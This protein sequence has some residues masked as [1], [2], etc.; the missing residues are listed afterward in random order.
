MPTTAMAKTAPDVEEPSGEITEKPVDQK[1]WWS[2]PSTITNDFERL[3]NMLNA[4]RRTTTFSPRFV[5]PHLGRRRAAC[6]MRFR[7]W[8]P[9][10]NLCRIICS[11][12]FV[13]RVHEIREFAE[14]LIQNLDG[15][16][17]FPALLEGAPATLEDMIQVFGKPVS[18]DDAQAALS[19]IQRLEPPG[20]GSPRLAMLCCKSAPTRRCASLVTLITS[21]LE[22]LAE[23]RLP[24]IERKTGY[25]LEVI[26]AA[27]EELLHLNPRP[28]RDFE[29]ASAPNVV[30]DIS[31]EQDANGKY[32]VRLEDEYTPRLNISRQYQQCCQRRGRP[33]N[34]GTSIAIDSSP[35]ADR[36]IESRHSTLKPWRRRSSIFRRRL[37]RRSA[38]YRPPQ[39]AADCRRGARACDDRVAGRRR[40]IRANAAG[41]LRAAAILR[42]R[43]DDRRRR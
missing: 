21:H 3:L 17:R 20:V 32:I 16:G 41:N 8:W 19:F 7:I 13:F 26:K 5:E 1:N 23:N 38:V 22:D 43:N 2:I 4:S 27:R 37:S 10:R 30:P 35:L 33:E 14:F 15:N 28:G 42:R 31:I 39:D 40:Q 11:N 6:A 36:S 18:A 24:V 25:S 9:A 12:S 29:A 34:Q